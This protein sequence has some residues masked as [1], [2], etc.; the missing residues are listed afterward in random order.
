[1]STYINTSQKRFRLHGRTVT[2]MYGE[3]KI[4]ECRIV[5]LRFRETHPPEAIS[6]IKQFMKQLPNKNYIMR[7]TNY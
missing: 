3:K 2:P 7:C 5:Q 1:M 4:N 6:L